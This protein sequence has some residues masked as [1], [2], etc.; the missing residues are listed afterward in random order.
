MKPRTVAVGLAIIVFLSLLYWPTVRWLVHSWLSNPYYSHGF[1]IPLVSGFIV[2]TKRNELKKKREPS[3]FGAVVLGL[4]V[5]LYVMGSLWDA[6]FLNAVSLLIV[7]SGL[8]LFLLG[9]RPT[10]AISFALGFLLFMIPFPFIQDV[11]FSLQTISVRSSS[12]LLQNIG[13]PVITEGSQ[14]HLQDTVFTIGLP[15]SGINMLV[16]LLALAAV[17]TYLLEGSLFKRVLLFST[18]LPIAILFNIL[19]ISFIVVIAYYFNVESATGLLHDLSSPLFFLL[20]FLFLALL[21]R[22]LGCRLSFA[23]YGGK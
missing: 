12:W 20:A 5:L 16:A 11:G 18:S 15:C 6:R 2:W 17:Y 1:L 21:G 4:G 10:Q 22:I 3:L 14:I 13:L 23:T 9:V 8:C 19:R 7:I